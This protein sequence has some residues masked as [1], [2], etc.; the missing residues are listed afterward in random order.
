MARM[1]KIRRF[2]PDCRSVVILAFDGVQML[3]IAGPL[4]ALT[5]ANEEGAQPPYQ[6]EVVS[7][8]G[9]PVATASGPA[10]L[11]TRLSA[12]RR[13]GTL[14]IPGGP[15]VHPARTSHTFV[16]TVRR[17]AAQ[18][19]RV[20]TICTGAFLAAE[21]GLLD[22][23]R[24]VTHWRSCA[25]LAREYPALRVEE[26]PIFIRDGH[27]WTTA[28]VTSGIDMTLALIEEDHDVGV[29]QRVA[30]RLVVYL[31]RP[32]G[33]RQFSEPLI[34]QGGGNGAYQSLMQAIADRPT[35][36]WRVEDMAAEAKQG[37]RT[38][39]RR[40]RAATGTTPAEAVERIRCERARAL[41]ETTDLTIAGVARRTGFGSEDVMR[42]A[43]KR[44]FGRAPAELRRNRSPVSGAQR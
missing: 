5:T 37:V 25:R 43:V 39:F 22:G 13:V 26:D 28:G 7:P 29:A 4:Q 42:R 27:V 15:G 38:F 10:L 32:G 33:Q 44:Y 16:M 34:L 2:P 24:V 20:C 19:H 23:R 30:R 21:A 40:F 35:K 36:A 14:L 31:R 11:T 6:V 9:G 1:T 12:R 3:D 8:R 17:L 41:L 18:A